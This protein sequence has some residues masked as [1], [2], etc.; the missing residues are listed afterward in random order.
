MSED[1]F[2]NITSSFKDDCFNQVN[3]FL[4]F[5]C[6]KVSK[7]TKTKILTYLMATFQNYHLT[8]H[9]GNS[10]CFSSHPSKV[11]STTLN[12]KSDLSHRPTVESNET[13][14]LQLINSKASH[15]I[16]IVIHHDTTVSK[17]VSTIQL[18]QSI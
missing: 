2:H 8:I 17:E 15:S 1:S 5:N 18:K 10:I 6:F 3:C 11:S 13:Q 14:R 7:P 12:S 4:I 16:Q 9:W